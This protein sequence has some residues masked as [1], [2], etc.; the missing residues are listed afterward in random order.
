MRSFPALDRAFPVA[1]N[2]AEPPRWTPRRQYLF[3]VHLSSHHNA[4]AAAAAAGMSRESAYRLRRREPD[5][6]FALLWE[7]MLLS[8][9]PRPA[10]R[11]PFAPTGGPQAPQPGHTSEDWL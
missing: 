4:A 2:A 9:P 1:A 5:G 7:G 3:L 10:P 8:P 6:L 11:P